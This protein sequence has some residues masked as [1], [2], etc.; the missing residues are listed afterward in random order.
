M[1][2]RPDEALFDTNVL[3]CSIYNAPKVFLR[4]YSTLGVPGE[5]TGRQQMLCCR[6]VE[7]NRRRL[8]DANQPLLW[9]L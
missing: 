8:G 4:L 1:I 2:T 7:A 6:D 9:R 5:A 3:A